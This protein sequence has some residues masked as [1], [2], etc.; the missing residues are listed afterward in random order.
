[1]EARKLLRNPMV[2]LGTILSFVITIGVTW[3]DI[4]VLNRHDSLTVDALVPLAAAVLVAAHLAT[5]RPRRYKTTELWDSLVTS[6]ATMTAAHLLSALLLAFFALALVLVQLSYM[7]VIGGVATPRPAIILTGPALVAFA[8]GFGVALGRWAPRIFVAPL[9]LAG[10]VAV[11]TVLIGNTYQHNREWLSLWVSSE[12]LAGIPSELTLRPDGWR[13]G[14]FLGLVAL[15]ASVAFIPDASK[16][17][18]AASLATVALVGTFLVANQLTKESP[19]DLQRAITTQ[20]QQGWTAPSCREY[21]SVA[22]CPMPGYEPWI[23]R[24]RRPTEGVLVAV[25]AGARPTDLRLLQAPGHTQRYDE[26]RNSFVSRWL[27]REGRRGALASET[28]IHPSMRWGR[29]SAQGESELSIALM[30]ASRTI[31]LDS[32]FRLTEDDLQALGDPRGGNFKVGRRRSQCTSIEQGRAIVALWLAAQ[33]T[34]ATEAEFASAAARVPYQAERADGP[35]YFDP[36]AWNLLGYTYGTSDDYRVLWGARE[37]NYAL[38]LLGRDQ[39]EIRAVVAEEWSLLT[40]PATTTDQAAEVLSLRPLPSLEEAHDNWGL[41]Y[42]GLKQW[43]TAPC[44]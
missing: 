31:G 37:T 41:V 7:K 1:M 23:D 25:P 15:A 3:R 42:R 39:T 16:R 9:G 12:G 34:G 8:G 30:V 27:D 40:D 11:C 20:L 6:D 44:H 32:R 18:L 33:A 36:L 28:D 38:Q 35:T 14:Y 26:D 17:V 10:V 2:I 22:Y 4:P 21:S 19:R 5:I 24:W 43:G 13:L 29:N